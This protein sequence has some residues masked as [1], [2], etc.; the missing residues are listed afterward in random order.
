PYH[1]L[2]YSHR[3]RSRTE[4]IRPEHIDAVNSQIANYR[5][6]R[7]LIDQWIDTAIELDRL[8]RST[9]K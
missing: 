2:S 3:G 1:Q 9:P 6:L 5:K 7:E 8:R 4:N